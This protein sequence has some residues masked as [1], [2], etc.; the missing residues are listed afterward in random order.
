MSKKGKPGSKGVGGNTLWRATMMRRYPAPE[1]WHLIPFYD[2]SRAGCSCPPTHEMGGVRAVAIHRSGK[3]NSDGGGHARAAR[4]ANER[5]R[6]P[7][8]GVDWEAQL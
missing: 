4:L 2:A 6:C 7:R 3:P 5:D 1:D 8:C